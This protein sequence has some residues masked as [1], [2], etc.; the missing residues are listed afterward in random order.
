MSSFDLDPVE[1]ATLQENALRDSIL[2]TDIPAGFFQGAGTGLWNGLKSGDYRV[3]AEQAVDDNEEQMKQRYELIKSLKPD[4]RTIGMLGQIGFGLGEF[5]AVAG[6]NFLGGDVVPTLLAKG[7]AGTYEKTGTELNVLEGMDRTTAQN[8]AKT[9]AMFQ[10]LGVVAP[11][12]VPGKLLMRAGSG[13]AIQVGMGAAERASMAYQL[14]QAGYPEMAAQY[15]V[16]DTAALLTDAILGGGV[17]A[18]GGSHADRPA[19][20]RENTNPNQVDALL[21]MNQAAHIETGTAPGLPINPD[22]RQAHVD[23]HEKALTDLVNG[24]PVDV[25]TRVTEA[26]FLPNHEADAARLEIGQAIAEHIRSIPGADQAF[27]DLEN[28][29]AMARDRGLEVEDNLFGKDTGAIP[30]DVEVKLKEQL[31]EDASKLVEAGKI[32]I[33]GSVEELN[34]ATGSTHPVDVQAMHDP[35]TGTS[36]LVANNI[37]PEKLKGIVLHE[38][39]VHAGMEEMLGADLYKKLLDDVNNSSEAPFVEARAIAEQN[40]A[41][42]EHI[43]EETLAYLV[44]N[45]KDLPLV[46]QIIASA[47]QWL[48]RATGGKLIN[49]TDADIAS[50]AAAS[51]RRQARQSEIASNKGNAPYY[52]RGAV[53]KPYGPDEKVRAASPAEVAQADDFQNE[54][55]IRPYYSDGQ[56]EVPVEIGPK[57]SIKQPYNEKDLAK[58]LRNHPTLDLPLNKNG[59][60]TLYFPTTNEIARQTVLDK[61][62]RAHDPQTNR[63][64]L[65]NESSA[66]KIAAAPGNIEQPVGGA[67]V[68]VHV[69][70]NLLQL[71]TEHADGRKD[72]FIQIAE[73]KSFIDKMRQTKLFTL[74]KSRTEAISENVTFAKIGDGIKQA[75]K[76]LDGLSLAERRKLVK[77]A[78]DVLRTEHNVGTLLTENGKLEK[79][80]IG[81]YD[82]EFEGKPVASMGLGL[83]SAQ[84]LNKKKLTTCL[85]SAICEALCL[86]ETSGQNLLYGGEGSFRSG[87]RLSQY[88]K[89][90][91]L[92]LHPRE[93]GILLS[94]EISLLDAWSKRTSDK[95]KNIETGKRETV[96]KQ[97]YQSAI[98]LNVTSDFP[99]SVFEALINAHPEIQFYD[100]TKLS[101]NSIAGNHHLTYSSTGASQIVNGKTV[102]NAHSN[103]NRMVKK[104]NEGFNVAMAFSNRDHLPE[105]VF[106][107]ATGQKFKVWNGDKYDARFL[108]PKQEDGIGMIIGLTNKDRTGIPGLAAEKNQGFFVDYEPSRD[109]DTVVIKDQSKFKAQPANNNAPVNGFAA[110]SDIQYSRKSK[111]E[112]KQ[113]TGEQFT[114]KGIIADKPDMSIA[115]ENGSAVPAT[116]AIQQADANIATAKTESKAFSVAVTCGLRG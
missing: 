111:P 113:R 9:E 6:E 48:Y 97:V 105:F 37:D 25:G 79:T 108:D 66:G 53:D 100:Y 24:N 17:A 60:V 94:H 109:G 32:K 85:K 103:W 69:D 76:E 14:N 43:P 19:S 51:L 92:V 72:Y 59:T 40:A 3:K 107:E 99:P 58:G 33:V 7:V 91:A 83:A 93:F 102:F 87:P 61:K 64:Y 26:E 52:S 56:L 115:T 114:A 104:M 29:K 68:L 1:S 23:A 112:T 82:I 70:P 22:A 80:R 27:I 50:M 96:D 106:D 98:R 10:G 4:P 44:E 15:K 41:Q 18:L 78:K 71:D 16:F 77:Q 11:A 65:T 2:P 30:A 67:N 63:I 45:H 35:K 88:L 110:G 5:T 12:A 101:T 57:Y 39:G 31:G 13:A 74:N 89:T 90:E 54:Y 116:Q 36:Y 42:P 47:R 21:T 49:L 81:D 38:V 75:M 86:G 84:A 62:L 95:V 73:G 55:G 28:L 8:V 46:K 34:Q 20:F